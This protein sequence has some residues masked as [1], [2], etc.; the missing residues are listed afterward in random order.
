[1][2][3]GNNVITD[4]E[5]GADFNNMSMHSLSLNQRRET[6]KIYKDRSEHKGSIIQHAFFHNI[7]PK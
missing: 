4:P 6:D 5:E 1:V 7:L 2:A 3:T